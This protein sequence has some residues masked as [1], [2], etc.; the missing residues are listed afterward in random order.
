MSTF[1]LIDGVGGFLMLDK[2]PCLL[3]MF[4]CHSISGD[5]KG[6]AGIRPGFFISPSWWCG[7]ETFFLHPKE[8]RLYNSHIQPWSEVFSH[9]MAIFNL[10]IWV[11]VLVEVKGLPTFS[12]PRDRLKVMLLVQKFSIGAWQP[13]DVDLVKSGFPFSKTK[14]PPSDNLGAQCN[15]KWMF[16]IPEKFSNLATCCGHFVTRCTRRALLTDWQGLMGVPF[17][18]PTSTNP[19]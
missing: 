19:W 2:F 12:N 3:E 9:T 17:M 6:P 8:W 15:K 1:H 14:N 13:L 16:Q 5:L 10:A 18:W 11:A 4:G 7:N